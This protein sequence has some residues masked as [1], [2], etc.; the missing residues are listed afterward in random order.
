MSHALY[1]AQS[2]AL[3]SLILKGFVT[4]GIEINTTTVSPRGDGKLYAQQTCIVAVEES[5]TI[6]AEDIGVAPA[7]GATS[8]LEVTG[9]KLAGGVEFGASDLVIATAASAS[10][11]VHQVSRSLDMEGRPRL[12]LTLKVNSPDGISSGLAFTVP[13]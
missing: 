10:V 6:E 13:A 1:L 8:A 9:A 2:A 3:G 7:I 12:R 4:V 11:T 5:V